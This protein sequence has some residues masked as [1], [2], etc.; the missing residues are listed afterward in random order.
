MLGKFAD[1]K[2]K[3]VRRY[4]DLS[5]VL[6]ECAQ[7]Y[8][9]DVKTGRFPADEEVYKLSEDELNQLNLHRGLKC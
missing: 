2:P 9:E 5:K 6:S 3:F 8:N 1:F 4:F 7:K